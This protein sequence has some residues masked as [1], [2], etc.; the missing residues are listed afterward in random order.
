MHLIS[1]LASGIVGAAEGAVEL[2]RRGTSLR[3]TWYADFEASSANSSGADIP[4]DSRGGAIVYVNELVRVVVKDQSGA[5][6][7]EFVAGVNA[8][9]VEVISTAFTGSDYVDANQATQEPTTLASALESVFTSF[10]AADAKVRLGSEDMYLKDALTRVGIGSFNVKSTK[11]GALG[12]ST[13]DDTLAIQ[14]AF[15]DAAITGGEVVFPPGTYRTTGNLN[16]PQN[17]S[18]RGA[19][20]A[21]TTLQ[22]NHAT[23]SLLR[24]SSSIIRR[25][26]I[27]GIRFDL[28]M[29][30]S[31]AL[32]LFNVAGCSIVVRDCEFAP[33]NPHTGQL[34]S[35]T[36]VQT[37]MAFE[38]CRFQPWDTAVRSVGYS[39]SAFFLACAYATSTG[40]GASAF[41]RQI[42]PT[43]DVVFIGNTFDLSD[44]LAGFGPVINDG[45]GSDVII[46]GNRF[47]NPGSGTSLAWIASGSTV[48]E[49]GNRFGSSFTSVYPRTG[50]ASQAWDNRVIS[51]NV[52]TTVT[53]SEEAQTHVVVSSG[54]AMAFT[55]P[56]SADWK[57][58]RVIWHNNNAGAVNATFAGSTRGDVPLSCN[59]NCFA[60]FEIVPVMVN[61]SFYR[62]V[63]QQ[64]TNLA[65]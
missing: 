12:N 18:I 62:V 3:A 1:P 13:A 29:A 20:V 41:E 59:G 58:L 25:Q 60:V 19:G 26:S 36:T 14:A 50:D 32:L 38:R 23:N 11:Y 31:G 65:E 4:L 2:Y 49:A 42:A 35:A 55:L 28:A 39:G 30:S 16:L 47:V 63:I 9:A 61:A 15:T 10:G 7:R 17:V 44:S 22:L 37:M 33:V 34:V 45:S 8:E 46:V 53:L 40:G 6:L 52:T 24:F 54:A 5:T 21:S 43:S 27:S 57:P 48:F 51:Y 56:S 64:K